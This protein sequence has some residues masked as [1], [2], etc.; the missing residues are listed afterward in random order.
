MPNIKLKSFKTQ[1]FI[2][3]MKI[4]GLLAFSML[5]TK[6]MA[7]S[8]PTY[9]IYAS[10]P[11]EV[12]L[13][14]SV[15]VG[16]VL[17]SFY[18]SWSQFNYSCAGIFKEVRGVGAGSPSGN[19][20]STGISGISYRIHDGNGGYFPFYAKIFTAIGGVA[21]GSTTVDLIKSSTT[22]SS[23]TWGSSG[24][25]LSQT[26]Y[27]NLFSTLTYNLVFN[28][29]IN[30]KIPTCTIT[31]AN[32]PVSLNE[33]ETRQL[34]KRGNTA[35]EKSFLIPINCPVA[36]S[37]SL[38]FSGTMADSYN[39]VF[40]NQ[41]SESP[42][43]STLGMQILRGGTPVKL[44]TKYNIGVIHGSANIGMS[45]RY[46]AIADNVAAGPVSSVAYATIIYN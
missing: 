43:A 31:Q 11:S 40:K 13:N 21:A 36:R 9:T 4:S 16:G 42:N 1:S 34:A 44:G 46:Y 14:P 37:L 19:L 27:T 38:E 7:F 25:L 12:T 26:I 23:G 39:G 20:Y 24:R 30:L 28:Q 8:C 17:A 41:R 22:I 29:S 15:G 35:N 6:A 18:V 2:I 10:V 32:I 33:A 5:P 3:A 45:A